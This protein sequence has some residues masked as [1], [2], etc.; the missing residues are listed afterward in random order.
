MA[1]LLAFG[2]IA[3]MIGAAMLSR[4]LSA[5]LFATTSLDAGAAVATVLVVGIIGV[6]AAVLP[7]LRA[8]RVDAMFVL[9]AE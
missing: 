4:V 8:A 5:F 1:R 2:L 9:R 6:G 3:G 7:A